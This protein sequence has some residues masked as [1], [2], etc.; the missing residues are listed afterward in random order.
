MPQ[1]RKDDPKGSLAGADGERVRAIIEAAETSAAAIRA[2]VAELGAT[3]P[4]DMGRVMAAA[5]DRF[6]GTMDMKA[7][8][9]LVKAALAG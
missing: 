3:G 5:K 8:S 6:G 4:K 2:L 9:G 7:A 1:A